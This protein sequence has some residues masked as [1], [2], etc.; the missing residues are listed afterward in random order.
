MTTAGLQSAINDVE[1][2]RSNSPSLS[3][4]FYVQIPPQ[5][6]AY[7]NGTGLLIPQTAGS[8][9]ATSCIVLQSTK[10]ANLPVGQTVGS[11]GI[12]DNLANSTDIGLNNPD[13]TGQNMYYALGASMSG[14]TGHADGTISGITTLSVNTTTLA[15]ISSTGSNC[16]PLANGYVAPGVALTVDS[17]GNAET[18]TTTSATNQTGMCGN[19]SKT[20][21]SGVP[22]TFCTSGCSYTLQ[23]EKV[24]NTNAYNDVQYMWQV[25][26]STINNSPVTF[27]SASGSSVKTSILCVN[28]LGAGVNFGP[29]HWLI[30]DMAA[31]LPA[32]NK[33]VVGI[34]DVGTE[35]GVTSASQLSSHIH[36]QRVFLHGDWTSP[37]TGANSIASGIH[38]NCNTCSLTH[39]QISQMQHPGAEGHGITYGYGTNLK[40]D[41]NWIEGNSIGS[42]CG[43]FSYPNPS[44]AGIVPCQDMEF[45]RNRFT[46]PF[47][48][49]GLG[50]ITSNPNF[51]SGFN[52]FR[53]NSFERK[54]GQRWVVS[55]NIFENVDDTGG[56]SGVIINMHPT[57][58]SGGQGNNYQSIVSDQYQANNIERNGCAGFD[59]GGRA[60]AV[61]E[62]DGATFGM[63][64]VLL[65]SELSYSITG[66]NPGCSNANT[67]HGYSIDSGVVQWNG[68]VTGNGTTA[69]FKAFCSPQ[70]QTGGG[71]LTCPSCP[72]CIAGSSCG[73][74]SVGFQLLDINIGNL[75][76]ISGCTQQT[77]FNTPDVT[78]KTY[79]GLANPAT[80]ISPPNSPMPTVSWSNATSGS[81][82]SGNC[83]LS[84]QQGW[85][86]WLILDHIGIIT[87]SP[88]PLSSGSDPTTGPNYAQKNLYRDS[89][90]LG[91]GWI[92]ISGDIGEGTPS[93]KFGWDITSMSADH[94]VFPT[95]LNTKYT[96]YG[97]NPSYSDSA[98]CTGLGCNPPSTMYFPSSTYCSMSTPN[99]NCMGFVGATGTSVT[100]MPLTLSDYHGFALRSDSYFAAGNEFQASDGTS[101]GPNI[102]NIDSAQT[103]TTFSC[104]Y[105]C[106]KPGPYSD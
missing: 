87:D 68:T 47:A 2:C 33:S 61:G 54:V 106:G 95:R 79:P 55:G 89:Y 64:Y 78:G 23:N 44:I 9:N 90:F 6:Y 99:S 10:D 63:S 13:G 62:G 37:I 3:Y 30:E 15:A 32:G 92:L 83:Q 12:Q 46:F 21:A 65:Q 38:L 29:D 8:A 98:G 88:N 31:A 84:Y 50:S 48:W 11:H 34:V 18:V 52:V 22:V 100:Y 72:G 1:G 36:F 69:T 59:I 71:N 103:Q 58:S 85:P 20:H 35:S 4:G 74:L 7:S 17:G 73:A 80:A 93:E 41:H 60:D 76:Q 97:N 66:T 67:L 81:D 39:S 14:N 86:N 56:Q 49:L 42:L 27:C 57:N 5:T 77:G 96:E 91:G 101:M 24:I 28:S 53:K 104:S 16:V 105:T 70:C 25:S 19:F 102:S 40:I 43:G 82:G 75:V 94:L 51:P 45:R 26:N